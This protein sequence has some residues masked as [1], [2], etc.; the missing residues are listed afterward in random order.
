MGN[1]ELVKFLINEILEEKQ[2][3]AGILNET[4]STYIDLEQYM[5]KTEDF[6]VRRL[7]PILQ[8]SLSFQ[9]DALLRISV[10]FNYPTKLIIV[11]NGKG[12]YLNQ[13]QDLKENCIYGF[14]IPIKPND[15]INLMV[16]FD[17]TNI[18]EIKCLFLRLFEVR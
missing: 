18:S 5:D 14:D 1:E 6:P 9:S 7:K 4:A 13:G 12:A 16:D 17:D 10:A 2:L 11:I 15:S 3:L 8:R